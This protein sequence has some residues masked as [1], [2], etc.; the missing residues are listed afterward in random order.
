MNNLVALQLKPARI[1]EAVQ[2]GMTQNRLLNMQAQQINDQRDTKNQAL[3]QRKQLLEARFF[4]SIAEQ[5]LSNPEQ[6]QDIWANGLQIGNRDLGL[7]IT[8]APQQFTPELG[9]AALAKATAFGY[10]PRNPQPKY[11]TTKVDAN[12]NLIGINANTGTAGAI[13][14][15]GRTFGDG[16]PVVTI[17]NEAEAKGLTEEQKALAASRVKR[18]EG[19]QTAADN[20]ITQDEQLSQLENIDVSTGFGTEARGAL[21][22][23]FNGVFGDGVGDQ[24][25]D[26]N[27]PAIQAFKGVSSRLVNSE[28]NKAKGPQ[29][30]GDAKRAAS[31][32]ANLSNEKVANKFLIQSL[33]ATNARIVEQAEFYQSVFERDGTLKNADKEWLAFKRKTPMLSESW[34]DPQTG[35]PMFYRDFKL[36]AKERFPDITDQEIIQRWRKGK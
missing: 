21:A 26:V 15:G 8:S 23:A 10:T 7:D 4:G 27:L 22:S 33:R 13:D 9:N 32:L 19:I 20:A 5:A 12:G 35:L 6:A 36:R 11:T 1:G 16:A 2:Q 17:K 25:L 18:F 29:T 3:E 24:M 14:T 31:T 30:E 34:K 28:L